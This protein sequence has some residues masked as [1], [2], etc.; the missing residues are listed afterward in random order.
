MGLCIF[1]FTFISLPS[2]HTLWHAIPTSFY[3]SFLFSCFC[4]FF[5]VIPKP[6]KSTVCLS[7]ITTA[8]ELETPLT[9]YMWWWFQASKMPAGK[10]NHTPHK[11]SSPWWSQFPGSVLMTTIDQHRNCTATPALLKLWVIFSVAISK[12]LNAAPY[13]RGVYEPFYYHRRAHAS[14]TYSC[15]LVSPPRPMTMSLVWEWDSVCACVQD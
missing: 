1:T 4:A 14:R 12:Q 5:D 6:K 3:I 9:V 7:S 11:I 15:V 10:A 2:L 8:L 13:L